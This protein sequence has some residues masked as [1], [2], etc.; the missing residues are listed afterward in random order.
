MG[1]LSR[2]SPDEYYARLTDIDLADLQAK[3]FDAIILDLDNTLLPW[4]SSV[5][6][7]SSRE[8]VESAKRLGM[9]LVILSN[10]HY[11]ARLHRIASELGIPSYDRALKPRRGGFITASGSVG[12]SPE[13]TVVVGD[14]VLTDI[15]GGNLAQMH[16][17]LVIPM[18]RREF[19]GT[20]VSRVFE[21]IIL[22]MLGRQPESGTISQGNQ[23][24]RQ[25]SR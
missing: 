21:R 13:R 16:T 15:L 2:F 7:D 1:L 11:P 3:G 20:K 19:V 14:Q 4:K 5:T 9:K 8:W 10:T 17:I 23:S 24:Q 22:A 6:P 25:D 12:S 18:D